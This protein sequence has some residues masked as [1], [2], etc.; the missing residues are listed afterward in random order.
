[1]FFPQAQTKIS[2]KPTP[3]TGQRRITFLGWFDRS[4]VD[5]RN[6]DNGARIDCR[7]CEL[8][9]FDPVDSGLLSRLLPA[10]ERGRRAG[11][12]LHAL[13]SGTRLDADRFLGTIE[14]NRVTRPHSIPKVDCHAKSRLEEWKE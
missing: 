7:D 12:A 8:R 10:P 2:S 4:S 5:V 11:I 6:P 9:P 3:A 14:P 1:M 13:A